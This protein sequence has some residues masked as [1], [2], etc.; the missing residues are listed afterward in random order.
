MKHASEC[1]CRPCRGELI[2]KLIENV[3]D[4]MAKLALAIAGLQSGSE[5]HGQVIVPMPSMFLVRSPK[6][7]PT[8]DGYMVAILMAASDVEARDLGWAYFTEH[9]RPDDEWKTYHQDKSELEVLD[10]GQ[11]YYGSDGRGNLEV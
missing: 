3:E 8:R 7:H 2:D 4:P 9:E 6:D 11:E 1:R 10:L 5:P